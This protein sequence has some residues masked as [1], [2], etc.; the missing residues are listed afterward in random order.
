MVLVIAK[1]D[2]P[3]WCG[4]QDRTSRDRTETVRE[5]KAEAVAFVVCQIIGLDN[6]HASADYIVADGTDKTKYGRLAPN[7]PAPS[8]IRN[9]KRLRRMEDGSFKAEEKQRR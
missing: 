2:I 9:N 1:S 3:M 4:I 6:G 8:T 5:T 7:L